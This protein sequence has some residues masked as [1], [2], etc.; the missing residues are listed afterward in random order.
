MQ[1]FVVFKS[2]L[3]SSHLQYLY[4]LPQCL[5]LLH[6]LSVLSLHLLRLHRRYH[7]L[8]FFIV[9]YNLTPPIIF[10]LPAFILRL[11]QLL[12]C[13]DLDLSDDRYQVRVL[14]V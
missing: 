2:E 4:L 8:F 1:F 14:R 12:L 10:V 13:D 6:F 3:I 11:F 7:D 9:H 5:I